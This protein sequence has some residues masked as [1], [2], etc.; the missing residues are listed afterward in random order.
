MKVSRTETAV[1]PVRDRNRKQIW[2]S[3]RGH[4]VNTNYKPAH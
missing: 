2:V 3:A 4:F 1:L